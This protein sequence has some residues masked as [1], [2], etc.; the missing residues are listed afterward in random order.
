MI[1]RPG[2][3]GDFL[4]IVLSLF[5]LITDNLLL[6]SLK[7]QPAYGTKSLT[8]FSTLTMYEICFVQTDQLYLNIQLNGV[9]PLVAN[10]H[11]ATPSLGKI[12][13]LNIYL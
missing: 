8:E 11:D 5:N 3:V 4:Q 9:R 2:E 6:E 12:N 1:D 10:P 7:R 13:P